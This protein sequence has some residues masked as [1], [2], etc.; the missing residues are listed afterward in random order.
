MLCNAM[1]SRLHPIRQEDEADNYCITQ[2]EVELCTGNQST[3]VPL[4][5]LK[6]EA[7]WRPV[8]AGT[9]TLNSLQH[10]PLQVL[11]LGPGAY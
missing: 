10:T 4:T 5:H 2:T 8:N 3:G 9:S 6:Q 7:Y 11:A 1:E